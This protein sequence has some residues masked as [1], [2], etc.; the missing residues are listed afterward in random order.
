MFAEDVELLPKGAFLALLEKY[1]GQPE[2]LPEQMRAV[3]HALATSRGTLDEASL[4]SHF[5][6]RGAWTSRLPQILA[7]LEALGR[8]RLVKG[9]WTAA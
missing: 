5:T 6:G 4:A 9:A 1:R 3:A 7:T 2:T 8:A